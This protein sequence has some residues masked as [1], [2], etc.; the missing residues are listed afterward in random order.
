MANPE[1]SSNQDLSVEQ[2]VAL[3]QVL[4]AE[5]TPGL[6]ER[7]ITDMVLRQLVDNRLATHESR[8]YPSPTHVEE[9]KLLEDERVHRLIA[10][11]A[12][13]AIGWSRELDSDLA[14]PDD[15]WHRTHTS[16]EFYADE[17]KKVTGTELGSQED[18][19][20]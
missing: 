11:A 6:S 5:G 18:H 3:K 9:M 1:N 20:N 10:H 13:L 12:S 7:I 15:E 16:P 8:I 17:V 14:L 2:I 4:G 19:A